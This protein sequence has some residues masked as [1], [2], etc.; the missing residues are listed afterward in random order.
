MK[1]KNF[2]WIWFFCPN[3]P[4]SPVCPETNIS[5]CSFTR[6]LENRL[7][8]RIRGCLLE[9]NP[10]REGGLSR[11]RLNHKQRRFRSFRANM[12]QLSDWPSL[13]VRL[14][15]NSAMCSGLFSHNRSQ[16]DPCLRSFGPFTSDGCRDVGRR[17]PPPPGFHHL[18]PIVSA[19]LWPS[20]VCPGENQVRQFLIDVVCVREETVTFIFVFGLF[21]S[22]LT[23]SESNRTACSSFI[24]QFWSH[25]Q[26]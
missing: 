12:L 26:I 18:V 19:T 1:K 3:L 7:L 10:F 5:H 14:G 21:T 17:W 22:T 2:Y 8:R 13:C 15:F 20:E 4:P 9:G 6:T 24:G 16:W 25:V 11:S 23:N